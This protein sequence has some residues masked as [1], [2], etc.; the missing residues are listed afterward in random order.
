MSATPTAA[1]LRRAGV[2]IGIGMG[3]FIDGILFHQ[4]FQFHNMLSARIPTSDLLG[5]KVNM[6][7]DGVFHLAVWLITALGIGL[8]FRAGRRRDAQWSAQVFLPALL[9]G[10]GAFNLV[11][12]LVNHHVLQ[13]HHVYEAAGQSGWDYAFL[14]SGLALLAAGWWLIRS[15]GRR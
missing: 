11:E 4:I 5:V 7:W 6:V 2:A 3:G 15:P 14:A 9:I 8:L 13:L 12:G 10:W 1:P